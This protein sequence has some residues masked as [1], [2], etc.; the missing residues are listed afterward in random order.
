MKQKFLVGL[1]V[2]AMMLAT[3]CGGDPVGS[4]EPTNTVVSNFDMTLTH[5]STKDRFE[6]FAQLILFT[7]GTY[8]LVGERW[9]QECATDPDTG[10]VLCSLSWARLFDGSGNYTVDLDRNELS[11]GSTSAA[12]HP[13][14]VRVVW[15]FGGDLGTL[16]LTR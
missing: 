11:L 8:T 14:H 1:G 10:N 15:L 7:D 13:P 9:R 6:P 5:N 12:F 16:E 4:E 2:S 3:G